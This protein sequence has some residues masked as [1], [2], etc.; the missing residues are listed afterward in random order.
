MKTFRDEKRTQE[1]MN[2]NYRF[3]EENIQDQVHQWKG[4][5]LWGSSAKAS[6]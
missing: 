5:S 4:N 6:S 2:V 3:R 1:I